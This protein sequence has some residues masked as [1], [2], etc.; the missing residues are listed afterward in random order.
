MSINIPKISPARARSAVG[1][2]PDP[3]C[4]VR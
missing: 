3:M 4:G 2:W 1:N